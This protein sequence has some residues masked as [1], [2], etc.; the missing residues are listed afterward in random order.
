VQG[1][2]FNSLYGEKESLSPEALHLTKE[3]KILNTAI[4]ILHY[5]KNV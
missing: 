2:D 3:R 4:Q 5:N 1:S